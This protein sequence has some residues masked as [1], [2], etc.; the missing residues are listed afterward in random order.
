MIAYYIEKD[1]EIIEISEPAP[2]C[3]VRVTSP[4]DTELRE[5]AADF[6]LPME[7]VRAALDLDERSRVDWGQIM[8]LR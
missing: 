8:Y 3:W 5:L 4:T 1:C 7:P 2:N 6:S